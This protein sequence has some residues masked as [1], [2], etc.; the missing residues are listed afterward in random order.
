MKKITIEKVFSKLL[1]V[2][3]NMVA[4]AALFPVVVFIMYQSFQFVLFLSENN[5]VMPEVTW[6]LLAI[7]MYCLIMVIYVIFLAAM[8][9]LSRSLK[10]F[11]HSNIKRKTGS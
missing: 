6:T 2:G 3:C 7:G 5:A 11:Y 4:V 9:V 10:E 8:H 1:D